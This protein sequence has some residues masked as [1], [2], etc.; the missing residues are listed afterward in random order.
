MPAS[1]LGMN[2]RASA[3]AREKDA[4]VPPVRTSSIRASE[5]LSLNKNMGGRSSSDKDSDKSSDDGK[6]SHGRPKRSSLS[7]YS[8]TTADNGRS[9]GK[10]GRLM[11]RLG[12]KGRIGD[13]SIR[14]EESGK[15]R[16]KDLPL[17]SKAASGVHEKSPSLLKKFI[18]KT[19]YRKSYLNKAESSSPSLPDRKVKVTGLKTTTKSSKC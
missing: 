9:E 8:F 5:R 13:S 11:N 18:D 14:V 10:V 15:G 2:K 17:N 19:P 6:L 4:P 12:A 1:V 16:P 3:K 7:S